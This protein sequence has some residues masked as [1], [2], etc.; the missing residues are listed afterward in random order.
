MIGAY[1][2]SE[3]FDKDPNQGSMVRS[4]KLGRVRVLN[5]DNAP[6]YWDFHKQA[7]G[8]IWGTGLFRYLPHQEASKLYAAVQAAAEV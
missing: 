3:L 2:I 4:E 5:L 7:S 1:R 6:K 8:P